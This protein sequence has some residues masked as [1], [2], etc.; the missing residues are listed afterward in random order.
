MNPYTASKFDL[1][2][3]REP[4]AWYRG[5]PFWSWNCHVDSHKIERDA[6]IFEEMGFGGADIHCRFGLKNEYLGEEFMQLVQQAN[7]A[8]DER[9]MFAWLYDEDRWPS[10]GAGGLIARPENASRCLLFTPVRREGS[11]F[12]TSQ[13][14][15][16]SQKEGEDPD[17]FFLG[18]YEVLLENG[19]LKRYARCDN[20][21][22]PVFGGTVW[23]AYLALERNDIWYS[24]FGYVDTLNPRVIQEFIDVTYERYA[25]ACG[26]EFGKSIPVIFTDEPQF[27]YKETLALPHDQKDI[28]LSFTDDFEETY[29]ARFGESLLDHLPELVWEL[30]DGAVS[31]YRYR[32]HDH[33]ANRFSDAYFSQLYNWCGVHN[34]MLTG[35]AVEESTLWSQTRAIGEAMRCY[36]NLHIPGIDILCDAREYNTVKQAQSVSRQYGRNGV[37]SELYGV[38]NWDF[39]FRGHKVQGDWQAAMGVTHRVLSLSLMSMEGPSKRDYPASLSYQVPWYRE[40]KQI[41]NYFARI[42]TA[43]L[44]GKGVVRVGVIHPIESY[45]L[46]WGPMLQTAL[47]RDEMEERFQQL[48]QWLLFGLI[49]FDFISE[50]L[51]PSQFGG[52][53]K[54]FHVGEMSYDVILVPACE[55]LRSTTMKALRSFA[56]Q[57]GRVLFLD[58]PG[59]YVDAVPSDAI[60]ELAAT[61]ETVPFSKASILHTLEPV[62]DVDSIVQKSGRRATDMLYQLRAEGDKKFLF[63]CN[64][65]QDEKPSF[66]EIGGEYLPCQQCEIILN[67][68]YDVTVLNSMTG[69]TKSASC[70]HQAGKT[71]LY[72]SIYAAQ[73]FLYLLMPAAVAQER[74]LCFA[75]TNQTFA[76]ELHAEN[77]TMAEPNV[78]LL[79]MPEYAING[80]AL[81]AQEEILRIQRILEREL[82]YHRGY[83]QPW[84]DKR[85]DTRSDRITFRFVIT[86]DARSVP[87]TLGI[88]HP[89]YV[90]ITWNGV[91][92][93]SAVTGWYVDEAIQT[94]SLGM[95]Q[96]G[97]NELLIDMDIGPKT[98]L[99]PFY[100]LGN[101]G[102]RV[103]GREVTVTDLP[104]R[105]TFG[106]I[107]NQCLPF[108]SGSL[109]YHCNFSAQSGHYALFAHDFAAPLL[110]VSVDGSRRDNIICAPYSADLGVLPAGKHTVDITVYGNRYNTFGPLHNSDDAYD[111]YGE[112]AWET[113]GAYFAYEYHFKP[114][115]LF[116][117]PRI[118]QKF[119]VISEHIK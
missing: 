12:E 114:A 113:Q 65:T 71:I 58:G 2:F 34:I 89:E 23:Y 16:A 87:V 11:F 103:A 39:T 72:E 52:C 46:H 68:I 110:G 85:P 63:L 97:Q 30:A 15:Y 45:W 115:G 18:R 22:E 7:K 50:S 84:A 76:G 25:K 91:S 100:L 8:L 43:M 35:H 109:T 28:H 66:F 98:Y 105:L 13:E 14:F 108:Y 74:T 48:T 21:A 101:F 19:Y 10:G 4:P 41:E 80:G 95:L 37:M 67:G 82:D 112:C 64:V 83:T 42:N 73:S 94:V 102:V 20:T 6:A 104:Q 38:T 62:R 44:S 90:R 40:Y 99:E 9:G 106:N 92:I 59:R 36:Q 47:V 32:Y 49:D 29:R 119:D 111:W 116:T 60:A 78:L 55:T 107:T 5:V 88:E 27:A 57:G 117:C 69:E 26:K 53:E 1:N 3:F 56:Q 51:L 77:Y 118:F 31:L 93:P 17:G 81:R 61:C 96:Q 33:I 79:D 86:S 54:G 75:S 24:G 70:T